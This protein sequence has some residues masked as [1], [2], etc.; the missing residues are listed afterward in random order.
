M[1]KNLEDKILELDLEQIL[2]EE[3]RLEVKQICHKCNIPLA[4][5]RSVDWRNLSQTSKL[6]CPECGYSKNPCT[7]KLN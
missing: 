3:K 2:K 5:Y 6:T 7:K 1:S 4:E